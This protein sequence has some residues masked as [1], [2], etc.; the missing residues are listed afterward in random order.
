MEEALPM[1]RNVLGAALALVAAVAVLI[2]PFLDWYGE[3]QGRQI[4]LVELFDPDGLTDSTAG[5]LTG[6]AVAMLVVAVVAVVGV[7]LRS[8]LMVALAGV[9]AIGLTVLWMARRYEA[10]D[11]LLVGGDGVQ[12]GALTALAAGLAMLIAA[13]VMAGRR[14]A[15]TTGRHARTAPEERTEPEPQTRQE[16]QPE[17]TEEY[18]RWDERQPPEQPE[19]EQQ[20][21]HPYFSRPQ[22]GERPPEQPQPR[23]YPGEHPPDHR[24]H[25]DVA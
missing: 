22:R 19:E 16:A 5:L 18:P 8:R 17:R 25:R 10:T 1:L 3:R 2:S 13:V 12:A 24:D 7:V 4:R 15:V 11:S 20:H 6:L 9:L 23:H 14:A 21:T